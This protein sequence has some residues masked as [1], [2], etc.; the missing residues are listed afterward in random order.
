M[1]SLALA[2]EIISDRLDLSAMKVSKQVEQLRFRSLRSFIYGSIDR[3][4]EPSRSSGTKL[5]SIPQSFFDDIGPVGNGPSVR[6]YFC[7]FHFAAASR[8]AALISSTP[9]CLGFSLS[10][11]QAVQNLFPLWSTKFPGVQLSS[12]ILQ[13]RNPWNLDIISVKP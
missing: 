1:Y 9:S 13:V 6:L 10:I 8:F 7:R 4:D 5:I 12:Q 3:Q 2:S 11:Q